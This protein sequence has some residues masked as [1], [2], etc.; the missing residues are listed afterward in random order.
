MARTHRSRAAARARSVE[1]Q[2]D[3]SGSAPSERSA[4]PQALHFHP[5][6]RPAPHPVARVS[7]HLTLLLI[8]CAAATTTA[9]IV[10]TTSAARVAEA[11]AAE[12][13]SRDARA[14]AE[15]RHD[16]QAAII[17]YLVTNGFDRAAAACDATALLA[18]TAEPNASISAYATVKG[19][20]T[21]RSPIV[22][23]PVASEEFVQ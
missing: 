3:V 23:V 22:G 10:E 20:V 1:P 17:Q 6:Q 15:S 12:A 21:R 2:N 18:M 11:R 16:A 13:T 8:A 19:C 7:A 4:P 5:P 9:V 14:I